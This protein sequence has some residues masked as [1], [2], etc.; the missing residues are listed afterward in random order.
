M[1]ILDTAFLVIVGYTLCVAVT[2]VSSVLLIELLFYKKPGIKLDC[3]T[4]TFNP[5]ITIANREAC[6]K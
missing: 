4:A 6:R 5:D 2:S 3:I 1:R